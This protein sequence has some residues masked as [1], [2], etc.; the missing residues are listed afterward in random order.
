[1]S[2]I[3][4][5]NHRICAH[6]QTACEMNLLYCPK[7]GAIIVQALKEES[8]GLGTKRLDSNQA[9]P[10]NIQWGTGYFTAQSRLILQLGNTGEFIPLSVGSS[11]VVMGRKAGEVTPTVDLA[12]YCATE[13]GVSRQHARIDLV[14]NSLQITDLYSANGTYLNHQRLQPRMPYVLQN[15]AV[16]QLGKLVLR[17]KFSQ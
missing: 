3:A 4:Q 2:F 17:I 12:P 1:M 14:R 6:C 5:T 10:A 15:H 16:I 9:H 8:A 13:L 7:C 11:P